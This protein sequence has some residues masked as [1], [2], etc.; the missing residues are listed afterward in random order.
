MSS[1]KKSAD[2]VIKIG[3]IATLIFTGFWVVQDRIVS[4]IDM[5]LL[6][7]DVVFLGIMGKI[8]YVLQKMDEVINK[9][10]KRPE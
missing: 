2:S 1:F 6:S 3:V 9:S 8:V 5:V 4:N 10:E 7:L